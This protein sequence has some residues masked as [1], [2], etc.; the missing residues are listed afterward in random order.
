MRNLA[1]RSALAA[2]GEESAAASEGLFA[3]AQELNSIV[4]RLAAEVG[5]VGGA[6]NTV[7]DKG[8]LVP[9]VV[10]HPRG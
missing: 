8:S 1:Q 2:N 7:L 5:C 3:Q 4:K 10:R 6:V 9:Q